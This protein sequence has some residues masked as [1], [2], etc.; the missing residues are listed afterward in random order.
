MGQ[1]SR[2]CERIDE[3]MPALTESYAFAELYAACSVALYVVWCIV[4]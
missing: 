3:S 4:C 2:T 1:G